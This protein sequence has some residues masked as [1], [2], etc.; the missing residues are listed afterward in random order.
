MLL[1]PRQTESTPLLFQLS[2]LQPSWNS[3]GVNFSFANFLVENS[4]SHNAHEMNFLTSP[5][6]P[7][8]SSIVPTKP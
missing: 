4:L 5:Q 1:L 3:N 6:R 7:N 2:K 8:L